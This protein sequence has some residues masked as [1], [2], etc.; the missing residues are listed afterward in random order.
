[1]LLTGRTLLLADD[2][3][4]VQKV[5]SLVFGDEG[6][7]VVAVSSGAEA[8]RE[9]EQAAPDIVLADVH[10]PEPNGYEVC[11]HVKR[12]RRVP[13][14]LLVGT[15]EPFNEAEARR[16]G[17]DDV[18]TKPFQ[19]IRDL[20][21][22]VG[23]LL[24]GHADEPPAEETAAARETER[25]RQVEP[26]ARAA[27]AGGEHAD[28]S[29]AFPWAREQ[30]SAQPHA[31]GTFQDFDMDDQTIQTTS[32]EAFSSRAADPSEASAPF[33]ALD[34][35]PHAAVQAEP[36]AFEAESAPAPALSETAPALSESALALSYAAAAS[37]APEFIARAAQAVPTDD[38]LLDLGEEAQ[39]APAADEDEF[40]LDLDD[41]DLSAP[42]AAAEEP[43]VMYAEGLAS[44]QAEAA[45]PLLT[46]EATHT[47][48]R[49]LEAD[50]Q[51]YAQPPQVGQALEHVLPAH[52]AAEA[53]QAAPPVETYDAE[54][55]G[56]AAEAAVMHEPAI[57]E[58]PAAESFM[59]EPAGVE[60][61]AQAPAWAEGA[62]HEA[63]VPHEAHA[64]E[65]FAPPA[66]EEQ[67]APAPA[68]FAPAAAAQTETAQLSPE[69]IDA[70]ARR[71]V[72]LMSDRVVRE[73]AWEVVP[74]LAERLIKRR[75]AEEQA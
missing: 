36:A 56:V 24:G 7:T 9:L 74:D 38:A 61:M 26:Q 10:M 65:S 72:E 51:A 14:L 29:P 35:E 60:P 27:A 11:A 37:H 13:V 68:E 43:R 19:S 1:L 30:A 54:E 20:V 67:H 41:E 53:W 62:P 21:S 48:V 45:A 15:F 23:H 33:V 34:E 17:A 31:A 50:A 8:L 39:P 42:S 64:P 55:M 69:M 3:P 70:I 22:K 6:M 66:A 75:L 44:S 4:T 71:V 58:P 47:D 12:L 73:V 32:A 28:A 16:V 18:L 49:A 40:I 52:E 5:V 63:P 57:E 2:S 46:E 59:H 25:A